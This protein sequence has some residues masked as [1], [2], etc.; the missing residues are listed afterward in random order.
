MS[1]YKRCNIAKTGQQIFELFV[2]NNKF[3]RISLLKSIKCKVV[4]TLV[5][6]Y[7]Q[8]WKHAN[9]IYHPRNKTK[10]RKIAIAHFTNCHDSE[11]IYRK[12][13]DFK[14]H[15]INVDID[16]VT[17]IPKIPMLIKLLRQRNF[18]FSNFL[19]LNTFYINNDR[20]SK[21]GNLVKM[22]KIWIIPPTII[23]CYLVSDKTL[24]KCL[25][26]DNFFKL[27]GYLFLDPTF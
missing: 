9:G 13:M 17:K 15:L 26:F 25:I 8:N 1:S 6:N 7:A 5:T 27:L 11:P 22:K 2:G 19:N 14:R 4:S 12:K 16:N 18:S 3:F 24:Q 10:W 21:K 23:I 20:V